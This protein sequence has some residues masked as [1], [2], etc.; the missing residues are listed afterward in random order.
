M[1]TRLVA[2]AASCP[3]VSAAEHPV[4]TW[5][6]YKNYS[7]FMAIVLEV[8]NI[9]PANWVVCQNSSQCQ[10]YILKTTETLHNVR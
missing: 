10:A 6:R 9:A 1:E 5:Q 8:R 7:Q 2:L 4:T 3:P